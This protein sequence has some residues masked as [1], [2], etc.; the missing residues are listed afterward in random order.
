MKVRR[1]SIQ[2]MADVLFALL[3]REFQTR[4]GSRRM[5]AFWMIFEPAIHILVMLFIFTVIRARSIQGMDYP[6]F[7]LSGL[8]PFFMMRNIAKNLMNAVDANKA[9]FVYPNIKIL[10][11]YISRMLVE[12]IIY[13]IIYVIFLFCLGYWFHFDVSIAHPLGFFGALLMGVLFSF[14][15]GI[16]LSILAQAM[17]S[18]K[19]F[20]GI[21][22]MVFY[23]ISGILFPL[24]IIPEKYLHW[25]LWNPYA[26]II[27]NIRDSAF[28]YYPDINGVNSTYPAIA[29]IVILFCAFGLYKVRK[30][31]LLMQ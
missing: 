25:V 27:S 14:G 23:L 8:I 31:R 17:P 21:M 22:F 10:D 9:L 7:L 11:T 24:W 15:L 28:L 26:H 5:G 12:I 30:E 20:V 13:G 6:L 4:F 2:I 29:T 18:I 16:L 19:S 1:T 3:L